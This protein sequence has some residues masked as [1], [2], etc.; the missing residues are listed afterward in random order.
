MLKLNNPKQQGCQFSGLF[1]KSGFE[2]SRV[3]FEVN[4]NPMSLFKAGGVRDKILLVRDHF[5]TNIVIASSAFRTFA[6][7]TDFI[8]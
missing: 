2:P 6:L 3:D 8:Y 7:G 5:R 1:R 4:V